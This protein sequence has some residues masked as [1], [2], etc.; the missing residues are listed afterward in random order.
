[1]KRVE[2]YLLKSIRRKGS[3][4]LSLLDPDRILPSKAA[5]TAKALE[6]A[7]TTAIMIGGSTVVSVPQLDEVVKSVKDEIEIPVILFPNNITGVSKFAD[8]VWFMSLLNSDN[9]LFI[10]GIQALGA[11]LIKRY[12]L[13][14]LSLGYIIV[15]AGST[16]AYIG[17]ARAVPRDKPEIVVSYALAAQ[18]LGMHFVYLEAGSGALE[19]VPIKMISEVK[20]TIDIPLVVGGGIR[21]R[22][23]AKAVVKA[24]A[25]IVVTGTIVEK[26][27]LTGEIV[28][29][30]K[31]IQEM[32]NQK[33][34]QLK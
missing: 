9:P 2:E 13:E 32:G 8:A 19:P 4:H 23:D 14:T 33:I 3:I 28:E 34:D 26:S 21:T 15:D 10:T 27:G 7:G 5:Q 16:A 1:M 22:S 29:I 6:A 18:Y 12:D 31:S 11:P 30:I 25:D 17:Q 20:N 24:G